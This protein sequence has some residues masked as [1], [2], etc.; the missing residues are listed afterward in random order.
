ME[1]YSSGM[2]V[3]MTG[4]PACTMAFL[5]IRMIKDIESNLYNEFLLILRS[6]FK[7]LDYNQGQGCSILKT[8]SWHIFHHTQ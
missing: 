5:Q 8:A 7:T 1:T 2:V 3:G 4:I 6:C